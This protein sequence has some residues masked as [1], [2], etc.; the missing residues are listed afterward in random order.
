MNLDESLKKWEE[1]G[2]N[3]KT[4]IRE[5][6]IND[7]IVNSGDSKYGVVATY[8]NI[9]EGKSSR[10]E[11]PIQ[12]CWIRE[13]NKFLV[14]DGYHRLTEYLLEGKIKYLCEIEWTGYSLK[15]VVPPKDKRF[16]IEGL[17]K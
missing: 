1:F 9:L 12:V 6:H 16:I 10:T 15:W 5:L 7:L 14:T 2:L 17:T 3:E 13:E 4:E 11:G 8:N